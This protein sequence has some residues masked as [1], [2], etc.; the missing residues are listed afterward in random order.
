MK[1]TRQMS[2]DLSRLHG[3]LRD[4]TRARALELLR[5]NGTLSYSELQR[6]LGIKH[7][8]KLNYH[9]GVLGD[10]LDKDET[11]GRYALSEKGKDRRDPPEQVSD[12]YNQATGWHPR[13]RFSNDGGRGDPTLQ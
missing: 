11:T 4:K 5:D 2:V 10:L 9:L 13:A 6:L 12:G 7:T 1:L 8:G 3:V